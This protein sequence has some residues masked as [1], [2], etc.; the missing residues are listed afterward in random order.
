MLLLTLL[1]FV[2]WAQEL[3]FTAGD[4]Y[5][6]NATINELQLPA[7]PQVWFVV[8][9][10]EPTNVTTYVKWY[11]TGSNP[12]TLVSYDNLTV[13]RYFVSYDDGEENYEEYFDCTTASG[14]LTPAQGTDAT[15]VELQVTPVSGQSFPYQTPIDQIVVGA[16][17]VSITV[18][19]AQA[20][21]FLD[22]A[23]E[24]RATIAKYLKIDNAAE[25]STHQVGEAPYRFAAKSQAELDKEYPGEGLTAGKIVVGGK[26]YYIKPILSGVINIV[27]G[28][29]ELLNFGTVANPVYAFAPITGIPY[30]GKAHNLVEGNYYNFT[31]WSAKTGGWQY[32]HG[33]VKFVQYYEKDPQDPE[34][35][36]LVI[37]KVVSN[38]ADGATTADDARDF[39]GQYFA[40]EVENRTTIPT[41]RVMLIPVEWNSGVEGEEPM[42]GE[43]AEEEVIWAEIS[44]KWAKYVGPQDL[45]VQFYYIS[46]KDFEDGQ[47]L[48]AGATPEA[49]DP[50]TFEI[51]ANAEWST[52]IPKGIDVDEYYIYAKATDGNTNFEGGEPVFIGTATIV[53]GDPTF[54]GTIKVDDVYY[55]WKG[56]AT[57]AAWKNLKK[58]ITPTLN[59]TLNGV[60]ADAKDVSYYVQRGTKPATAGGEIT[61]SGLEVDNYTTLE[62]WNKF[63]YDENGQEV[64]R[65]VAR[66]NGNASYNVVYVNDSEVFSNAFEIVRPKVT[67]ETTVASATY[68]VGTEIPYADLGYKKPVVLPTGFT[69]EDLGFEEPTD[70]DYYFKKGNQTYYEKLLQVGKYDVY[71]DEDDFEYYEEYCELEVKPATVNALA[72]NMMAAIENQELVFG[73]T[74]PLTLKYVNG[75]AQT[76]TE[77]IEDFEEQVYKN[78][79]FVAKMIKDAEGNDVENGEEIPLYGVSYRSGRVTNWV[80]TILPV[81]TWTVSADF[82]EQNADADFKMYVSSG[83]WTVTPRNINDNGVRGFGQSFNPHKTYTSKAIELVEE[84]FEG[85]NAR[86]RA[87]NQLPNGVRIGETEALAHNLIYGN[88]TPYFEP[89]TEPSVTPQEP[90]DV[91]VEDLPDYKIIGYKNNIHAGTATVTIQGINNFEGTRDLTFTIDKARLLVYPIEATWT[92]GK[93]EA[94]TYDVDGAGISIPGDVYDEEKDGPGR[95][96]YAEDADPEEDNP[97]Y[98]ITYEGGIKTQ[99]NHYFP[100]DK[101]LDVTTAKGFKDLVVLRDVRP[102][103]GYYQWGLVAAQKKDEATGK[104]VEADDYEFDFMYAPL[105]IEKGMIQVT[106]AESKAIYNGT[107]KGTSE[108]GDYVQDFALANEDEL[109]PAIAENWKSVVAIDYDAAKFTDNWAK[110]ANNRFNAGSYTITAAPVENKNWKDVFTS[111][112]YD[113]DFVAPT[114]PN[115]TVDKREITVTAKDFEID[116][117]DPKFFNDDDEFDP[118]KVEAEIAAFEEE[119][120][121]T[122]A[123]PVM[124]PNHNSVTVA[125]P[126]LGSGDAVKDVISAITVD[127]VN[128]VVTVTAIDPHAN[129]IIETKDGKFTTSATDAQLVLTSEMEDAVEYETNAWGEIVKDKEGKP[130]VKGEPV[131]GDKTK[132]N[133]FNG[134]EIR[135]ISLTLKA[136]KLEKDGVENKAFSVWN[137]NE[138]HAMVLPFAV[139][140]QDL[141]TAFGDTYVIVNVVDA[142]NTTEGD[143][144]FMLPVEIDQEIPANTPFCVKV[145]QDFDYEDPLEFERSNK[146]APFTI[147]KP[148]AWTVSVPAGM[149][150]TFE[151]NYE[152]ELVVSNTTPDLRFLGPAKWYFIKP[153][154]TTTKYYMQPYTGYVN[155]GE[156]SATRE[157]TF[158]F[159]EEDGSTTAIKAVDFF[160]GNKANAEGLYRV[161]GVKMNTVPTQKGVYIQNG[162]KVLK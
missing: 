71:V 7:K 33:T 56:N 144:K 122:T 21:P 13:G 50:E 15:Q 141:S 60:A 114:K 115:L 41:G 142:E 99:I 88:L 145:A 9:G 17:M 111:N 3:V 34:D 77:L 137:K 96:I 1:P 155:L 94:Y 44:E 2:G 14:G 72:G 66:F 95:K 11:N 151:G 101:D 103:V 90:G 27:A 52:D 80:T 154:S 124:A 75:Y 46:K 123:A 149:G 54:A 105:T 35:V 140:A 121:G 159:E 12:Y 48:E 89:E 129:Y 23:D 19:P 87:L 36:N 63:D 127:Q 108:D 16:N 26:T 38:V 69:A 55:V 45:G 125:A 130:V 119:N 5:D 104:I 83:T 8:E 98:V 53:P 18:N 162:Q 57:T 81:G 20:N 32:A 109:I 93:E 128:K 112:N 28:E 131:P 40:I 76:E 73:E 29:N 132:L 74:L 138:W 6:A 22:E 161:D 97:L 68:P 43:V 61:W 42:F 134:V 118:S 59:A 136:P 153:E 51:P 82:S 150:Y 107:V 31:S 156:G 47:E 92:L 158:T 110:D 133:A 143:V 24:G 160:N 117:N 67:I 37:V 49:F 106:I 135:N 148:E 64:F 91:L 10:Q 152:Q 84:D 157:V 120:I 62:N 116:F 146:F 79:E 86:Y 4:T 139:T 102:N 30:D 147:V 58:E 113:V 85:T 126:G 100:G 65:L 78:G 70:P 25:L 39:V